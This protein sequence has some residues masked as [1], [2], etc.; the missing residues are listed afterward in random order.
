MHISFYKLD[1]DTGRIDPNHLSRNKDRLSGIGKGKVQR[2]F[3]TDIKR[4]TGFNKY[5]A[6]ADVMD[7]IGKTNIMGG[8]INSD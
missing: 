3:L 8:T 2:Y 6:I 4:C 7:E 5:A 1:A